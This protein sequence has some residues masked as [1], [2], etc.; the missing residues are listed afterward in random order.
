MTKVQHDHEML[1]LEKT[2]DINV[3]KSMF[4]KDFLMMAK[5]MGL[6]VH[7]DMKMEF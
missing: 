2:K 7:Y 3:I 4:D 6:L 1:S 5:W